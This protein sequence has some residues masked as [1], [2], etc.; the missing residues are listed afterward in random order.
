MSL[1]FISIH[2]LGP[3]DLDDKN[4]F[5]WIR[6]PFL[7]RSAGISNKDTWLMFVVYFTSKCWIYG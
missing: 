3:G 6:P 1:Y 7:F 4:L 2:K 5:I